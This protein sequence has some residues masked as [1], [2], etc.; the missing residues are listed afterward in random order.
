MPTS[1]HLESAIDQRLDVLVKDTGRT[2]SFYIRELIVK[3]I[4]DLE[5]YYQKQRIREGEQTVS[6][7][8]VRRRKT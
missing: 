3:G 7:P 8:Q 4:D 1:I 6:T 2:K 5:Q